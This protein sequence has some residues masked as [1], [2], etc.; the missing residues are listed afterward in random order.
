MIKERSGIFRFALSYKIILAVFGKY[1]II[2]ANRKC[3]ARKGML[4]VE[5]PY[6]SSLGFAK[7]SQA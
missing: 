6:M 5:L 4:F 1:G 7:Q 3:Y 2:K